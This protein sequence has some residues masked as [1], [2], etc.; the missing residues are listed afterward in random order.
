M[1]AISTK[2]HGPTNTKGSR[3]TAF[4]GDGHKAS[5]PY[6]HELSGELVHYEAVKKLCD[7]MKW[8]YPT[9]FGGTKDGYVFCWAESVVG[10]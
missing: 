1:K 5:V 6:P 7:K 9:I 4:D 8:D 2:Y 3:I 10:Q